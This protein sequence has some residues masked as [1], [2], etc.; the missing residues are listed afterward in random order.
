M[1]NRRDCVM[2]GAASLV[3]PSCTTLPSTKQDLLV[4][5][6]HAQLNPTSVARIV[7][8]AGVDTI[9][10]TIRLAR[11]EGKHVSISG[12]RHAMGG[13]QFASESLLLDMRGMNRI[14]KLERESGTVEVE[15]GIE[16]PELINGLNALQEG[17]SQPWA[18]VQKQTGADRLTIGGAL[19]ANVH[20]RGLKFG[21]MIQDVESF[22]LIDGD[23]TPL[24]CSRS[25]NRELF[26][27][28]I[29]GYGLFGVIANVKLRLAR[30]TKIRRV[31]EIA[32]INDIAE[33]FAQRISEGYT[34]GDFQYS[35]DEKSDGY[36][37]RGVFSCYLPVPMDTPIPTDQLLLSA[38]DWNQL[39]FMGHADKAR[40]F[41]VYSAYY[42]STSGQIYWSDT[43]QLSTYIEDYHRAID[44]QLGAAVR[45][46]E[47]ITEIYVP[48]AA[49]ADFMA[50]VRADFRAHEVNVIYGTVRLVERDEESFLAWAR[51]PW[52]C[53]IFNLH[54]VHNP[55]GLA[56]AEVDFRRLIDHAIDRG[57]S[58]YLTYHRW[59][60]LEQVESCHPRFIEFMRL[61]R[62]YDPNER[63]QSEWYRHYRDAFA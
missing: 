4:N 30:R 23:A 62:Q 3:I 40:A 47:M 35:T 37:G 49:L 14:L 7:R 5:D 42:L 12:S 44:T 13:Q 59:A 8:T 56:K 63:F 51:E 55:A 19:S 16:W 26:Q 2:L 32:H 50:E 20:G 46:T 34:Y 48:R 43:H 45:A 38:N 17:E 6:V 53:I 22:T 58:Y 41:D 33:A 18:I 29:G 11:T 61:K 15:S 60:S 1:L 57:G 54:V 25:E 52:A 36:L 21:P 10:N 24:N 39:I 31:V 28:A 9:A 27:L